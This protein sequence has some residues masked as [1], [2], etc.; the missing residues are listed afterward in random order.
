MWVNTVEKRNWLIKGQ[1]L[2]E[3]DDFK[4]FLSEDTKE[5][6]A[7]HNGMQGTRAQHKIGHLQVRNIRGM[8]HWLRDRVRRKCM[9]GLTSGQQTLWPRP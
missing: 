9:S 3:I 8:V 2:S 1:G 7:S 4:V 5:T 6:I